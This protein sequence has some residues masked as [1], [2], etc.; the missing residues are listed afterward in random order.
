MSTFVTN[1]IGRVLFLLLPDTTGNALEQMDEVFEI[2]SFLIRLRVQR[3]QICKRR[4]EC[5]WS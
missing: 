1:L 4:S 5:R 3:V 2:R